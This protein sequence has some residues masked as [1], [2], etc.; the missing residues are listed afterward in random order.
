MAFGIPQRRSPSMPTFSQG[1]APFHAER[2]LLNE[3]A[4]KLEAMGERCA[5][6]LTRSG[7]PFL[8]ASGST[9]ARLSEEITTGRDGDQAYGLWSW[10]ERLPADPDQAAA[11]VRRVINPEA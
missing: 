8:W 2:A 6:R 7:A 4:A 3:I 1:D 5:V 9:D 10:G 11:A